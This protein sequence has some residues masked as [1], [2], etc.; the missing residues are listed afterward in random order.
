M[1]DLRK[2]IFRISISG[3]VLFVVLRGVDFSSL[4]DHV[5]G[6]KVWALAASFACILVNYVFSSYRLKA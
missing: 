3:F 2:L 4:L 5:R 1:K 6:A